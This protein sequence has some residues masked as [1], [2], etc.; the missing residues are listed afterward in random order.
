MS[1][2]VMS[3]KIL[4]C[5]GV[6]RAMSKKKKGL[7]IALVAIYSIGARRTR[8]KFV[9]RLRKMGKKMLRDGELNPGLPCDKR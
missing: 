3:E 9:A 2:R 4:P 6:S 1:V 7:I 5:S 8:N